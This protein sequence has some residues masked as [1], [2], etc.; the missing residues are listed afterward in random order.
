MTFCPQTP[1]QQQM[2]GCIWQSG[3][4]N[5]VEAQ[6]LA[7]QADTLPVASALTKQKFTPCT[8]AV[9]QF[10]PKSRMKISGLLPVQPLTGDSCYNNSTMGCNYRGMPAVWCP[11]PKKHTQH[12]RD[13][14]ENA[15]LAHT[16]GQKFAL[17]I[18]ETFALTSSGASWACHTHQCTAHGVV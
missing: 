13:T 7:G 18:I 9:H 3:A 17:A 12:G 2:Q 4:A 5:C 14:P 15:H 1:I 10:A 8:D 6:T 16:W 11:T